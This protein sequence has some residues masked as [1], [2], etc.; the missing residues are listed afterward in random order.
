MN[1][2]DLIT[3]LLGK[4]LGSYIHDAAT[5]GILIALLGRCIHAIRTGGG[6]VGIYNAIVYGTNIPKSK[7]ITDEK[8]ESSDGK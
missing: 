2:S 3:Q 1:E 7:S 5:V 4:A 6:L 8:T